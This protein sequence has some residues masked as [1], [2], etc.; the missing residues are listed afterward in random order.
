MRVRVTFRV[1]QQTGEVELFQVDDLGQTRLIEGHDA[2]HEGIASAIAD[3]IDPR[4]DVIEEVTP[5]RPLLPVPPL[6]TD[7]EESTGAGDYE[8]AGGGG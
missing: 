4:A 2:A 6:R 7:E 5:A 8:Q 1:N 3:L